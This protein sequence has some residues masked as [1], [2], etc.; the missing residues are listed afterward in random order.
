M[1]VLG[2]TESGKTNFLLWFFLHCP[3]RQIF[4]NPIR[5]I[6]PRK[7]ADIN[8][9]ENVIISEK[10]EKI[11]NNLSIDRIC[12][13]PSED[14]IGDRK[15]LTKIWEILCHKVFMHE[16]RLF[17][18]LMRRKGYKMDR[19]FLR[20]SNIVLINDELM[21]TVH[22][23]ELVPAHFRIIHAG[24]NY[25]VSHIGNT[26]RHQLISKLLTTQSKRKVIFELDKY[27]IDVLKDRISGVEDSAY[28]KPFHF[29]FQKGLDVRYF[30]PVPL[31]KKVL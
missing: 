10:F 9:T 16:D 1:L 22:F 28:L 20:R 5:H 3:L 11:L 25:N 27:D 24:Q 15:K 7:I 17:T 14:L 23:E 4:F 30:L 31:M 26:Q 12:V 2:S 29:V 13:T 19:D 21:M 6:E 8:I 18:K